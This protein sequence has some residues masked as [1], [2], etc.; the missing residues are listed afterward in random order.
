[1]AT[2]KSTQKKPKEVEPYWSDMVGIWFQICW[3]KFKDKPVFDG[4]SPRDLKAIVKSLRER[5]QSIDVEWSL[6]TAKSRLYKFFDFAYTDNPWLRKNWL[7]SNLNR[8]KESIFFNL[9]KTVNQTP[10]D[11]FQ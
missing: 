3:D 8:Q 4:S 11:P 7:L 10:V 1:M 9:R 2:K 6:D 5:T